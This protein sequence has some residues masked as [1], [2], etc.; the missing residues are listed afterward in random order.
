MEVV[1]ARVIW[2]VVFSRIKKRRYL[3]HGVDTRQKKLD[4]YDGLCHLGGGERYY[5]RNS[6]VD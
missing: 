6:S 3:G 1:V 4:Q 2:A 5:L